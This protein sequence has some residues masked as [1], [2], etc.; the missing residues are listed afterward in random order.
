M[1]EPQ[2]IL[3]VHGPNLNLLGTR[4]PEIYGDTTLEEINGDLVSAAKEWGADVEFFQSN[5]EGAL[6]DRIQEAMTWAD[7]IVINPGGFT[8]TSVALR[9]ALVATELPIV[10]VHLSNVFAREEFR[11]SSYISSIALGVISGLGPTG[12]GLGLNALL[13][14]LDQ[15]EEE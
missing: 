7:G 13:E 14:H 9:D 10:E 2:R 4:E 5:H 15:Q 12:Y 1:S 6:I 11:R 8:H 3:V